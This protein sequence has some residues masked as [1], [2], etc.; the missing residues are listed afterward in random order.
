M[1]APERPVTTSPIETF[2]NPAYLWLGWAYIALL[3]G[4]SGWMLTLNGEDRVLATSLALIFLA[5]SVVVYRAYVV[6][7]VEATPAG[8]R[9]VNPF[10]TYELA[11]SEVAELSSVRHLVVHRT[12]GSHVTAWAV[13]A[14]NAARMAGRRSRADVVADRLRELAATSGQHVSTLPPPADTRRSAVVYAAMWVAVAIVTLTVLV[15]T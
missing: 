10:A 12:D 13:Q 3:F 1:T 14:A 2:R 8:V 5:K 4:M 15:A 9:V 7:R 6:A 11:W